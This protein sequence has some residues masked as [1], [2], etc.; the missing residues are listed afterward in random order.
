MS[1]PWCEQEGMQ[2]ALWLVFM[3]SVSGVSHALAHM[4]FHSYFLYCQL[5]IVASTISSYWNH[6][7]AWSLDT[8]CTLRLKSAHLQ[9]AVEEADG[10]LEILKEEIA[11]QAATAA[12]LHKF[13]YGNQSP[14]R[15]V[16]QKKLAQ[17]LVATNE[18][19][20]LKIDEEICKWLWEPKIN[21]NRLGLE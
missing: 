9:A 11:E 7:L 2:E 17:G 10:K 16:T 8:I 12:L 5:L 15:E 14:G 1:L 20:L 21:P 18:V 13:N 4:T 6:C 3:C 19:G